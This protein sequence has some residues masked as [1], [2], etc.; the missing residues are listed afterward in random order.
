MF[1]FVRTYGICDVIISILCSH[2]PL[3]GLK[4]ISDMGL[5]GRGTCDYPVILGREYLESPYDVL[6]K[7]SLTFF[8]KNCN[9]IENGN[10]S[11]QL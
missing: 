8:S 6:T 1:C 10:N 11:H 4:D 5:K 9:K 2:P 3:G 7:H